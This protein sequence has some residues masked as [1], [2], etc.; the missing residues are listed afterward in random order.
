MFAWNKRETVASLQQRRRRKLQ[1]LKKKK[2]TENHRPSSRTSLSRPISV[3]KETKTPNTT[4]HLHPSSLTLLSRTIGAREDTKSPD[5][6]NH[7]RPSSQTLLPRLTSIKEEAKAPAIAKHPSSAALLSRQTSTA[8]DHPPRPMF[9]REETKTP[10]VANN[11]VLQYMETSDKKTESPNSDMCQYI[12]V[13]NQLEEK[14]RNSKIRMD[15]FQRTQDQLQIKSASYL[16]RISQLEKLLEK[17]NGHDGVWFY[18][19]PIEEKQTLYLKPDLSCPSAEEVFADEQVLLVHP[20]Q[21]D[22]DLNTWIMAR[23]IFDNGSIEHYFVPLY[24]GDRCMFNN[25]TFS[26]VSGT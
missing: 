22:S 1:L 16:E 2:P 4:K 12:M 17:T 3:E 19:R 8:T 26:N 9:T 14:M 7:L 10:A 6:A 23:R 11:R 15:T 13:V 18:A 25:F 24:I 21:K 20:V 5:N